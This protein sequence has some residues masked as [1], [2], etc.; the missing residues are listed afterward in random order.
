MT[1]FPIYKS[2]FGEFLMWLLWIVLYHHED[3][4]QYSV[5]VPALISILIRYLIF[6]TLSGL[7]S[8]T[9]K[10]FQWVGWSRY[11]DYHVIHIMLYRNFLLLGS[12]VGRWDVFWRIS[13]VFV[14]VEYLDTI[15]IL[16]IL[17]N[18]SSEIKFEVASSG[19]AVHIAWWWYKLM[20]FA[21]FGSS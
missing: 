17:G 5:L 13:S 1:G 20:L 2:C 11:S 7:M 3:W 8:G 21:P 16:Q 19:S 18:V 6:G 10:T 12:W 4:S 15:R 9:V 14:V